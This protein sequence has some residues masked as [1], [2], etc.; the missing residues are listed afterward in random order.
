MGGKSL[1]KTVY[2]ITTSSIIMFSSLYAELSVEQIN[3]MVEKIQ[4]KRET[5][6]DIDY[7]NIITPFVIIKQSK[8][9]NET[10]ITTPAKKISFHLNAI[11]NN[12]ANIN[13]KW[14]YLG[15]KLNGYTIT[16]IQE[17]VVKLKKEK[18]ELELFLP[19]KSL[20]IPQIKINEG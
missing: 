18:S 1:M 7:K 9:S 17:R 19:K 16:D 13:G 20:K 6:N 15:D 4:Q 3:K 2:W 14:Y 5:K 8:E 10:V 11:I 12:S